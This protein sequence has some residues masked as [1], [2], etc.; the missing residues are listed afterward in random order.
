MSSEK[1]LTQQRIL[2]TTVKLMQQ[3][4]GKGVRI[5]EIARAV[6]ISRQAVYLHFPSRAD[7]LM[8]A[9][10]Y[11]D[12]QNHLDQ[13]LEEFRQASNGI[14]SLTSYIDFWGNYI[15]VIYGPAKA[16]LR[17][18]ETDRAASAAWDDRMAA[19]YEGCRCVINCLQREHLLAPNWKEKDAIDIMYG[20]LSISVWEQL[21]LEKGWTQKQYIDRIKQMMMQTLVS[22]GKQ[23][24][25]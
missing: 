7:L 6:G 9:G 16:L 14:R 4:H 3:K 10:R 23:P 17:A 11:I 21:T 22:P 25:K 15:P 18:S 13:R 20:I 24:D 8:A 1:S 19:M 5:E 12:E 2:E